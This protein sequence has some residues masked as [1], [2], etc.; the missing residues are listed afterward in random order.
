MKAEA[1]SDLTEALVRS[2]EFA[3]GGQVVAR[4]AEVAVN[5][6]HRLDLLLDLKSEHGMRT[7]PVEVLRH[8][9]P[10]DVRHAIWQLDE[11]ALSR[12][13]QGIELMPV[14]A[15]EHLS[16]GARKTLREH[17][18]G[19]FDRSGSLFLKHGSWLIDIDRPGKPGEPRRTGSLFTGAREMVVHALL[20]HHDQWLTGGDVARLAQTSSYTCSVVLQELQK[21]EW[22]ESKGAARTKR[23][24]LVNPAALLDAWAASWRQRKDK[25]TRWYTFPR[26]AKSLL[27][28]LTWAMEM[29]NNDLPW[30]FTGTAA[31]NVLSPLLTSVDTADLII[32][33]GTAPRFVEQ[34][35]LKSAE[36]GA[37]VTLIE[38][39]GT[40]FLFREMHPDIP[41]WFASPF[42][43][44]L[45]LL[46]GRGRNRELA[47]Q[48]R[49]D[50]L[51]V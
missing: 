28:Q 40:S 24:R 42:V 35:G 15:A 11:Y 22:L 34:L 2:L 21:L 29:S 10:R 41:S 6:G 33:P 20:T 51:K 36:K 50:I 9:Y 48:L 23:R 49:R 46:D 47:D 1:A 19:Y 5:A 3:T 27:L 43:Q 39:S 26:D 4:Q 14:V 37:N 45:D 17:G 44:Y 8:G 16:P 31:A 30:A 32:P 12:P 13:D 7:L 38:R 18:V 25:R